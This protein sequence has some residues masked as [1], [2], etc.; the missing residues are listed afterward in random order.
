[1]HCCGVTIH[2][3]PDDEDVALGEGKA[4]AGARSTL[5]YTGRDEQIVRTFANENTCLL[6]IA[7]ATP[8]RQVQQQYVATIPG[9]P[10]LPDTAA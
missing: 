3:W 9:V 4:F 7:Q 8:R 1:M 10:S 6:Q 5:H 2:V